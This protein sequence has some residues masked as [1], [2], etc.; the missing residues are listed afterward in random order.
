MADIEANEALRMHFQQLTERFLVPL[1]RYFQTLIPATTSSR[2]SDI[3]PFSLPSFL[4]H[5][6][7]TGPNP[8]AFKTKGLTMKSRV[9]HDFYA[10]FGMSPTFS[11]WLSG[12]I[13][14][15]DSAIR[16]Q[17]TGNSTEG[18]QPMGLFGLGHGG[19]GASDADRSEERL[20]SE[21]GS[22]VTGWRNSDDTPRR[23]T[24]MPGDVFGPR[25]GSEG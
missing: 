5:L 3:K 14:S 24:L 4:A 21:A 6:R 7:S 10:T 22:S 9:E 18:R 15:L 25:R 20:S 17:S 19:S 2:R 11:G 8:L 16:A 23:D 12:R 13:E 1:N